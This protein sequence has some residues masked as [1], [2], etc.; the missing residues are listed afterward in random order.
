VPV[1]HACNPSY[2]GGRDQEDRS[3]KP[4][5]VNSYM[6]PYLEN[7]QHKKGL[8]GV[9]M[10]SSLHTGKKKR[11]Q[12]EDQEESAT[13]SQA[14]VSPPHEACLIILAMRCDNTG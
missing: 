11:P 9:A 8:G 6:R 12:N 7:T 2:S 13:A 5:W 3:S 4:A 1:A 10:S 14:C